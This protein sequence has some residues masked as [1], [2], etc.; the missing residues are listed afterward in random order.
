VQHLGHLLQG[1]RRCSVSP[2]RRG[3]G[4]FR[5]SSVHRPR[6]KSQLIVSTFHPRARPGWEV[7]FV[8]SPKVS[9]ESCRPGAPGPM[10]EADTCRKLVR[11]KLEAAGWDT[12]PHLY[13]EQTP[14]TDGRIVVPGG[15]P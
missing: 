7:S 2:G 3:R 6:L 15:R 8:P 14:F 9:P 5:A 10:N 1:G 11:P 13:S 4:I 12:L